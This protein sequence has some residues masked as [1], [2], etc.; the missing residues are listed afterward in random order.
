[1]RSHIPSAAKQKKMSKVETLRHAVEYI[2]SLQRML[3]EQCG[4][5]TTTEQITATKS[6]PKSTSSLSPESNSTEI[7]PSYS[8][9]LTP[10]T[11]EYIPPP[12]LQ[13]IPN[14][15][16]SGYETSSY[17]SAASSSNHQLV[18]PTPVAY[19]SPSSPSVFSDG[20]NGYYMGHSAMPNP[21]HV[22][23]QASYYD[24]SEEDELLDTIVSWQ[25]QQ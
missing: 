11:P 19:Q 3:G 7:Q 1:M 5:E 15:N 9:P 22:M 24:N 8:A 16:E 13:Y 18:S 21:C 4:G 23:P 14:G 25:D 17:Y 20:S 10:T 6:K 2:Q 12:Q